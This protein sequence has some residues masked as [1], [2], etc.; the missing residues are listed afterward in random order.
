MVTDYLAIVVCF[1]LALRLRF[2]PDLTTVLNLPTK[3][4][5]PQAVVIFFYALAVL[6]VFAAVGL[7]RRKTLLSRLWHATGI[8]QGMSVA[9]LAYI[10]IQY[11][12]K[13]HLFVESRFVVLMWTVATIAALGFHRLGIAPWIW[14]LATRAELKRRIVLIGAGDV[15]AAAPAGSMPVWRSSASSR[16]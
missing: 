3:H 8:V 2:R 15:G 7:Y 5:V 16:M 9:G 14:R 4:M 6:I 10:A 13:S 11:L 1:G 12:T